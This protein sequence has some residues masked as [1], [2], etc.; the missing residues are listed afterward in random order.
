MISIPRNAL[1]EKPFDKYFENKPI[2]DL[3][4]LVDSE[5]ARNPRRADADISFFP[6][7]DAGFATFKDSLLT[8]MEPCKLH[9]PEVCDCP[10]IDR[11]LSEDLR[12]GVLNDLSCNWVRKKTARLRMYPVGMVE[13]RKRFTRSPGLGRAQILHGNHTLGG[14]VHQK[15]L[16]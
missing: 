4:K 8:A 2:Y 11:E 6:D 5:L 10:L 1:L 16:S 12:R 14:H 9:A 7:T 15:D 13:A 3:T